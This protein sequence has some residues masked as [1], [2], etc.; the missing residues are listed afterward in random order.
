[1]ATNVSSANAINNSGVVAGMRVIAEPG[2]PPPLPYNAV[3]WD[4][5]TGEVTDLG[6]MEGPNSNGRGINESAQIV[7]WTGQSITSNVFGFSADLNEITV[8]GAIPEGNT[9]RCR[10]VDNSGLVLGSGHVQT[11]VGTKIHTFLW[12]EQ[13]IEVIEP[14]SGFDHIGGGDLN[15]LGQCILTASVVGGSDRPF[16]WQHH[17]I[18]SVMNLLVPGA[19]V[20]LNSAQALNDHGQILTRTGTRAALLTP[21]GVPFADL[22]FD[23][24]VDGHDL[25]IL[26]NAW[27]P[28]PITRDTDG[29]RPHPADLNG[30][31]VVDGM[32][33]LILLANW[34]P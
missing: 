30:D 24:K 2:D 11:K 32:D 5:N 8:L 14:P 17:E 23:C 3:M 7:G 20:S 16:L 22:N 15:S 1:V 33:L 29:P 13:W 4:T 18:H 9:S 19:G 26:L 31:G 27:G 12:N 25:A 28:Q 6:V 21:I 34:N 10:A